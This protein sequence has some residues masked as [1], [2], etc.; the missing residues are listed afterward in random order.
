MSPSQLRASVKSLAGE[1]VR[2]R[3]AL[4]KGGRSWTLMNCSTGVCCG[5][6][7]DPFL[8]IDDGR[9][10]GKFALTGIAR[11][12]DG[13][14]QRLVCY[15]FS[16]Q[17]IQT[18]A[19]SSDQPFTFSSWQSGCDGD[20]G[21]GRWQ[22]AYCCSLDRREQAVLVEATLELAV[23]AFAPHRLVDPLICEAP[24]VVAP[25]Q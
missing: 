4:G 16:G 7:L 2:V 19:E 21:H 6:Q 12:P 20:A 23:H 13:N 14:E 10:K 15:S 5:H 9:T 17:M 11:L 25:L 1:R 3:G 18:Y 22:E 8:S 24:L